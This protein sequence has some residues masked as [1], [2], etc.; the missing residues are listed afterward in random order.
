[1]LSSKQRAYLKSLAHSMQPIFQIG[2]NEISD[3]MVKQVSDALNARELIKVHVL[4]TA[5]YTA[6]EAAELLAEATGA[7]VVLV[8]GTKFILYRETTDEKYVSKR[9]VLP[10]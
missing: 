5:P 1:M 2:K 7:D 4:E 9:I 3:A 10:R 6:R 8:I